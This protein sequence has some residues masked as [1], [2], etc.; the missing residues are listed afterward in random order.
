[1]PPVDRGDG[2]AGV[3]LTVCRI[4]VRVCRSW[5]HSCADQVRGASA[6]AAAY[7]RFDLHISETPAEA[8]GCFG[9]LP[10]SPALGHSD[11]SAYSITAGGRTPARSRDP[12]RWRVSADRAALIYQ[13]ATRERD[14]AI[15]TALDELITMARRKGS[16]KG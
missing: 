10:G 1:M 8:K 12:G 7:A 14:E 9:H 13:H 2:L 4:I 16:A 6:G 5:R 11:H 15:A 3:D